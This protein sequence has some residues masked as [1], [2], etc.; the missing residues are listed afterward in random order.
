MLTLADVTAEGPNIGTRIIALLS[1]V[2]Q[3]VY[4][5]PVIVN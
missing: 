2:T 4:I 1:I 5:L 3:K